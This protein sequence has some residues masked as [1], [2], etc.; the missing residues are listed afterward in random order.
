MNYCFGVAIGMS[1][2]NYLLCIF[3][4]SDD[5]Q[6]FLFS[7]L[8]PG[9]PQSSYGCGG[10]EGHCQPVLKIASVLGDCLDYLSP[11][12]DSRFTWLKLKHGAQV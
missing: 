7:L 6:G 1:L 8:F 12:E 4:F 2:L 11:R 10:R 3:M 9:I 5:V